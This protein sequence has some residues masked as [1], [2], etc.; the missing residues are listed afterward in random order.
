M[1][2][3]SL[4]ISAIPTVR[5]AAKKIFYDTLRFKTTPSLT[6]KSVDCTDAKNDITT[7]F[8]NHN[9]V[10]AKVH[11]AGVNLQKDIEHIY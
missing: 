10:P 5:L 6:F 8:S 11:N 9:S 4:Y 3:I 1:V 7:W 2:F